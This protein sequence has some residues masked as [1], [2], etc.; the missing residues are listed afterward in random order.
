MEAKDITVP[1]KRP[2]SLQ[3]GAVLSISRKG[4]TTPDSSLLPWS[5]IHGIDYEEKYRH[6]TLLFYRVIFYVPGGDKLYYRREGLGALLLRAMELKKPDRFSVLLEPAVETEMVIKRLYELWNEYAD[7]SV[8]NERWSYLGTD[9]ENLATKALFDTFDAERKAIDGSLENKDANEM[10]RGVLSNI[11][12]FRQRREELEGIIEY[13]QAQR[14]KRETIKIIAGLFFALAV[15]VL[16]E[17]LRS[18]W[19]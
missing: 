10:K 5:A 2:F 11:E 12:H 14:N 18:L 17:Y 8:R 9:R 1:I 15:M 7:P 19:D 4:V 13:E 16:V 6:G 3:K